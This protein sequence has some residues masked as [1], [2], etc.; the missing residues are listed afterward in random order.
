MT[1]NSEWADWSLRQ[2]DRWALHT[3]LIANPVIYAELSIG[4]QR[5]DE[6]ETFLERAGVGIEEISRRAL[7]LAGEAFREYRARGGTK[8]GVLP[9]FFIG[10]HAVAEG[11]S[12]LTRDVRRYRSYFP[13]ITLITPG[14]A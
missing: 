9:D 14:D 2:L 5:I 4:F 13:S 10:A 12:L 6:V 3:R 1:N 7:F 11:I 8:T